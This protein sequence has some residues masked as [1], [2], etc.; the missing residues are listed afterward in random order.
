MSTPSTTRSRRTFLRRT[1]R[2]LAGAAAVGIVRPSE[3]LFGR[4][5]G[6]LAPTAV[7]NLLRIPSTF[8]GTDIRASR[9][10]QEVWPGEE[11]PVWTWG[12]SYPAPTIHVERGDR[13]EV[14]LRNDLDEATII[15]WHGMIV[16]HDM[17]G[18]PTD[19]IGPG[20]TYDYSFEVVNRAG[21]YWYH[22]HAHGRSA[23]Q[24][25]MGMAG[26]FIVSDQAEEPLGLPSGPF[27]IP[28]L[29]QDRRAAETHRFEYNP[30]PTDVLNGFF[31]DTILAN[32]VPDAYLEVEQGLYRFRILNG[33]NA[34]IIRLGFADGRSFHVI[35]T[36]GGL[37][38]RPYEVS[39]TFL[40]P[41]E[42][43][44]ILVD[45]AEVTVGDSL[46]LMALEW[47]GATTPRQ[48]GYELP[49][50]RFDVTAP[51][52]TSYAIPE[53][54]TPIERIDPDS[55][56][57]TR[58][59]EFQTSPIPIGGVHHW[60]NGKVY[61][62]M[63]ID[64]GVRAGETEIW[65]IRN[66]HIMPHP[67]HVHGVQF[68][69]LERIGRGPMEPRDF[70]WKDT[71]VVWGEET[72]RLIIR[73]PENRGVFVFHCHNLEHEDAG[74]MINYEIGDEVMGVEEAS[75]PLPGGM[76]LR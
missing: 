64:A 21:T 76:D 73:F 66:T 74:M 56:A 16:P 13:F 44:E 15:H 12:G 51:A 71:V 47:G 58:V 2:A 61:D 68:Q 54:L 31:G 52:S 53:E 59:F 57:R 45:F 20:E 10:T 72:V 69:I 38:E 36:D 50:V 75:E 63:R 17:D 5:L 46:H 30:D 6:G 28:L 67:I 29:V 24:T 27:D 26:F 70:G 37:L 65:E 11:I 43:L 35:G 25:Y 18:H 42:R 40:A 62:M 4:V 48:P 55:A 39:E 7:G 49:I 60:I 41:A 8:T 22:P 34:R 23:P 1:L 19:A 9:H 32:G 33:S 14:R 3:R